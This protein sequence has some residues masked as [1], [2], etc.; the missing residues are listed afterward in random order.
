MAL[1]TFNGFSLQDTNFIT[2][3]ITF[4]GFANRS[5]SFAQVNRREGVKLLGS[6]FTAKEI[7][8]AGVVIAS[9][10]SEL[11]TLLDSMKSYLTTAEASL[12]I[13]TNRTYTASVTA[14]AIPD[15]HYNQ[16]RAP[17]EITFT[18]SKPFAEGTLQTAVIPITSGRFTVSGI[19]TI[20]GTLFARPSLTYTPPTATG[21]TLI[22]RFDLFHSPTSQTTT[23]SG[24]GSGTSLDYAST[25][26][27]NLDTFAATEA[28]AAIDTS[29]SFPKFEPG[30]NNFTFTASGRAFPGGTLA[31]SYQPRYI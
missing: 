24:F 9:T 3:R 29:G 31:I 11:Q 5:M 30:I 19:V 22:R 8:I 25:V 10:P 1:P 28:G 27:I 6:D 14:L 15:E 12:I 7:Q 26:I 13:E 17:Y 4:R 16:S 18:C 21:K 2:E 23:V 20:S